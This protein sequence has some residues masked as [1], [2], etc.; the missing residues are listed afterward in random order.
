[1][2]HLRGRL[3][4][5]AQALQGREAR[6]REDVV[7]VSI[8]AIRSLRRRRVEELVGD[9]AEALQPRL[10]GLAL[11]DQ[12]IHVAR[13]QPPVQR[14]ED[15]PSHALLELA[16]APEPADEALPQVVVLAHAVVEP[17]DVVPVADG[18]GREAQGDDLVH[19]LAV[20][21]L[22]DV[23]QPGRPIRGE[24]A[25]EPVLRRDHHLGEVARGAQRG[26]GRF[27]DGEM[28]PAHEERAGG[29][30]QDPLGPAHGA[31]AASRV[32]T[33]RAGTPTAT[34]PAGRSSVTTAPAPTT[35]SRPMRTPSSTLVPVPSH[36][37]SP[38]VMPLELRPCSSTGT[39]ARS[40]SWPPPT[41]YV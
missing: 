23:G 3:H 38:R 17:A 34:A 31:E 28:A 25:A 18:V 30:D 33:T 24:L 27:R 20:R 41:R 37:L 16:L 6:D 22:A 36:T 8:R 26:R 11:R 1:V 15:T 9:P 10:D 35:T 32:R 5:Q 29:D 13:E 7:A 40:N 21:G 12:A 4:Q 39:S 19:G 2:L 14:V